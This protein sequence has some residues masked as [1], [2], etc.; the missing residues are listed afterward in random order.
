MSTSSISFFFSPQ[1]NIHN[2]VYKVMISDNPMIDYNRSSD[3]K[4]FHFD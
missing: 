1:Y 4:G 3:G 2:I